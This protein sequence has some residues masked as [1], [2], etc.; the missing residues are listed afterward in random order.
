MRTAAQAYQQS[1]PQRPTY[2]TERT[3]RQGDNTHES[4]IYS[5][6]KAHECLSLYTKTGI[7]AIA[8]QFGFATATESHQGK[9]RSLDKA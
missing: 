3:R 9:F 4:R 1:D 2:M 5:R 6:D 8:M 7:A